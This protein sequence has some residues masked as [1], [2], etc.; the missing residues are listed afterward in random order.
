MQESPKNKIFIGEVTALASFQ[1]CF[2]E[3]KTYDLI[4]IEG[5]K[6]T[7][8]DDTKEEATVSKSIFEFKNPLLKFLGDSKRHMLS[9]EAYEA[10]KALLNEEYNY[11]T[12][13][14]VSSAM[15]EYKE[16]DAEYMAIVANL[17]FILKVDVSVGD[18][19]EVL[20]DEVVNAIVISSNPIL[21]KSAEAFEEVLQN[22]YARVL[23]RIAVK[24]ALTSLITD[25]TA[26]FNPKKWEEI[27]MA[28]KILERLTFKTN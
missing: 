26:V 4:S 11:A 21:S 14:L 16:A 20:P 28:R 22:K 12:D 5:S 9:Y 15:S 10:R 6:I 3:G 19:M 24:L 8:A 13:K 23:S 2:T 27:V 18:L 7:I 1:E 25:S 17:A